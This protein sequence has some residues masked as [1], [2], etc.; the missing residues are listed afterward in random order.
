MQAEKFDNMIMSVL[1][2]ITL[3]VIL[4]HT[5]SLDKSYVLDAKTK[6]P[7]YAVSDEGIGGTSIAKLIRD[8]DKFILQCEIKASSY[9]W[10]FCEI[11]IAI[12]L[13]RKRNFLSPV[14]LSQF[15]DV[16]VKAKYV[17]ENSTSLRFQL[18]TFNEAYSTSTD[19]SSWKYNGLE[20]WP[21]AD[22]T[23]TTIPL[24][25][26]QVATWWLFDRKIPI[27]YAGPELD[28]V[29]VVELATGNGIKPGYY[30][31][32]LEKIEFVG[33]VFSNK[34]VFLSIITMW[35]LAAIAAL[36]LNLQRSN[37]RLNDAQNKAKEL[38]QLNKLLSVESNVLKQQVERDPLTGALN[39][40][41]LEQVLTKS[42][43][44]VSMIFIDIDHFKT[45]NDKYGHGIGDEILRE[46]TKLVSE[47]SRSSD[48]LARWGGEEFLLICPNCNLMEAHDIAE[49]LREVISSH[50]FTHD[51]EITAS[52]GVAH[53]ENET[54][55]NLI[56]RA[57]LA[58]YAAKAQ[59]RNK[60]VLSEN[61]NLF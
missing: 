37:R 51:I 31:I 34:Q 10:P 2:L 59:G 55:A 36:I 20:Y 32:E 6:S 53:R 16:I 26:L 54:T 1:L 24:N 13:D 4:L 17:G 43:E 29:L 47:N 23:S 60:V 3:V 48:F 25:A 61:V 8:D 28:N 30:Q 42:L 15:T 44:N 39:R 57:D 38:K 40:I 18:R 12:G 19:D 22:S 58:L 45:L 41:G 21:E 46:F 33:K 52:F 14:D 5:F 11:T 35:A 27:K 56:E 49:D 7:V 9:A 50:P